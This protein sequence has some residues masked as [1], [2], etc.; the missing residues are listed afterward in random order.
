M[1][2]RTFIA[3]PTIDFSFKFVAARIFTTEGK[4]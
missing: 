2:N 4:K 1:M 3:I